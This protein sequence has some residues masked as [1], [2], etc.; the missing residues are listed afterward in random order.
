MREIL[1]WK[2]LLVLGGVANAGSALWFFNALPTLAESRSAL[3]LAMILMGALGSVIH[4]L[5]SG[6]I[7]AL[8]PTPV[9]QSGFAFPYSLGTALFSGL[10]PLVI[11]TLVRN[12]GLAAPMVQELIGGTVA[13][14][15][16]G[17]LRFLPLYL[18]DTA[19]DAAAI[20]PARPVTL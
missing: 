12:G 2:R 11:A 17:C 6:L 10:T 3:V 8:F 18:G 14:V 19:S 1:G 13:L 5:I 9:R 4:S 20:A 16:A 7:C 15:L